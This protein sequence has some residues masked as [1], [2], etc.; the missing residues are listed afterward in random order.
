[1]VLAGL[2]YSFKAIITLLE[3][4]TKD[5]SLDE[6][7]A[8]LLPVQQRED[9]YVRDQYAPPTYIE[10]EGPDEQRITERAAALNA[11]VKPTERACWIC[12]RPGHVKRDCP[13]Q[14]R[15]RG[16]IR[17]L[18]AREVIGAPS[19]VELM[20]PGCRPPVAI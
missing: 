14:Q 12:G 8:K 4:A 20:P 9:L 10:E 18:T 7:L 19:S 2:P 16:V 15:P 13:S 1:M 6:V 3:N 11:K 17:A 5:L